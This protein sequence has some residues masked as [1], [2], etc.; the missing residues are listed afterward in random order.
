MLADDPKVAAVATVV[1]GDGF[2]GLH[3]EKDETVVG[4]I[5]FGGSDDWIKENFGD[6]EKYSAFIE[7]HKKEIADALDSVRLGKLKDRREFENKIQSIESASE[8]KNLE[9]KHHEKRSSMNDI[10]GRAWSIAK[11][12][13]Q[14]LKSKESSR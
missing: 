7:S 1:L 12:I 4:P 11:S 14:S 6:T 5:A 2:Y 13:R 9:A 8:R 3:D 10:G